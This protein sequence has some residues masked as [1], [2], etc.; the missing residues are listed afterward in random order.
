[1]RLDSRHVRALG[2]C[3][4]GLDSMLSA[5]VLQNQGISVEW[6]T[7]ETPFFS[8]EKAQKAGQM[9]DIPVTIINITPIYLDMLK[10]PPGGFGKYLNPCLDCH[11]LMFR[12]AGKVM[13]EKGYD[14]LFSG[15]VL[16]QRPMSQTRS[17]L[18]YVEKH[19]GYD[20]FIL[21]PLSAKRLPET[22]PEKKG[23]VNRK[24]LLDIT[25]RSRK[26]QMTL[27]NEFGLKSYPAPAGGC[28]LTNKGYCIRL[29]DLF[30]RSS[31]YTERGLYLLKYGRHF[32]LEDGSKIIIGR[33]KSDNE[34]LIEY[35]DSKEDVL[36]HLFQ[37]P[38]PTVLIPK[39]SSYHNIE[40]AVRIATGYSKAAPGME[41][42]ALVTTPYH[43]EIIRVIGIPPEEIRHLMIQ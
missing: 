5:L 30:A 27:A 18:R 28:L 31:E 23:W 36:I 43:H 38:G 11:A 10:N 41:T 35:Y 42:S 29:K 37:I 8:P 25:G 26:R 1:M 19:S 9:M 13:E 15:E 4:G 39:A 24:L 32:R 14:F 3:S 2:L 34:H 21:R 40:L 20:G 7:F 22:L 6:V 17:S 33:S 16:G 12:L